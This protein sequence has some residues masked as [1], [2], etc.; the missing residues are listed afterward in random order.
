MQN[1]LRA[2]GDQAYPGGEGPCQRGCRLLAYILSNNARTE[3]AM[4][5][6]AIDPSNY[7]CGSSNH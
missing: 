3:F 5:G 6:P 7:A 4:T 2:I 1:G